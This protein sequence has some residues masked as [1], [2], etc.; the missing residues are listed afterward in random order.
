MSK[1]AGLAATFYKQNCIVKSE[2]RLS[3]P[4]VRDVSSSEGVGRSLGREVGE[5]LDEALLVGHVAGLGWEEL[6]ALTVEWVLASLVPGHALHEASDNEVG[7]RD[8][9]AGG[10]LT[11]VVSHVGLEKLGELDNDAA[12]LL[13]ASFAALI[14]LSEGDR[15]LGSEDVSKGV[16][17]G[18]D[19]AALLPVAGIVVAVADA[20][21]AE[22]GAELGHTVGLALVGDEGLRKTAT[23]LATVTSSL[24]GLPA[25]LDVLVS[26]D[27]LL[28]V[29]H[30]HLLE[31]LT[32]A[33]AGEVLKGDLGESVLALGG[34]TAS[35]GW[36]RVGG[37]GVAAHL[38]FILF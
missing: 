19:V 31:R 28:S 27:E 4:S 34:T 37:G 29:V 3:R 30:E 13:H 22:D 9:V 32:T 1:E 33:E 15:R 14:V 25:A 18:V 38:I 6:R 8:A 10:I 7:D 5:G 36:L 20:E 26:L 16:D 23:E 11:L 21:G 35:G 17:D 24:A 2:R 12:E